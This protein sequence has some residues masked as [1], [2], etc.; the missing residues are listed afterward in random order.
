MQLKK[1]FHI[2]S[3]KLAAWRDPDSIFTVLFS[4]EP[5]AF[6][7]DSSKVE[8][9][10]S[11]FSYIGDIT[12]PLSKKITY[13]I[14]EKK[15]TC[16]G[17]EKNSSI[18]DYLE[19]EL[20]IWRRK[21]FTPTVPYPFDFTGGFVGYFGYE[22]Q[23][24]CSSA[25]FHQSS[26]PDAYFFFIDRFLVFDHKEKEIYLV[27]LSD[28]EKE[29]QDWFADI[30]KKIRH[31][32]SDIHSQS[33]HAR[34]G[35][36]ELQILGKTHEQY[37]QDIQKCQEYL[38][39]GESYQICLTNKMKVYKK[40][41]PEDW[42][43]LYLSLR[44]ISPAPYSAYMRFGDFAILSSSP[45]MFL[46]VDTERVVTSK[47]IKGTVRR[48]ETSEEDTELAAN[49]G[50]TEK[51][52]A[53]N[54]MIVDLVRNDLGRVCEFGSI[55]VEHFLDVE[56]Y[57]TM[58]QLVSTITG[59]LGKE[60]SSISAIKACFPGGSMTGAPKLKAMEIIADLEEEARGI[61]S[62]SLGFLSIQGTVNLNIIIRTII[63]RRD[64]LCFGAG[65]AILVQSD[66]ESEYKEM[67]LKSQALITAI[68]QC[69]K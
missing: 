52:F 35:G 32:V 30:I 22:L 9:G 2:Y 39:K 38:Q 31:G 65:G 69:I 63:A 16:N 62:G 46:K 4:K 12:G 49:L 58:H 56:T 5:H 43:S 33:K 64:E 47:P 42:V 17:K 19:E 27:C 21:V 18:F 20:E 25:M 26:F 7:L 6:W 41:T 53:E 28:K 34:D 51:D 15:I 8:D 61:Y 13:T 44:E 24:D 48:G 66:P 59:K 60:S 45:E 54:A 68:Q 67:L 55:R 57:A 50:K 11:R 40:S 3:R 36:L 37:V 14:R 10:L 29:A 1:S 23:E